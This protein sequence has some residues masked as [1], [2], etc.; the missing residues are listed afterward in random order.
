[1]PR[2]WQAVDIG[3]LEGGTDAQANCSSSDGSIIFGYST[4]SGTATLPFRWTQGTGMV[5][6]ATLEAATPPVAGYDSAEVLS[7]TPDGSVCVGIGFNST[8]DFA[9]TLPVI[10]TGGVPAQLPIVTPGG[11]TATAAAVSPSGGA[12]AGTASG[13]AGAVVEW[14]SGILSALAL[15]D[16]AITDGI[17]AGQAVSNEAALIAGFFIDGSSN[18]HACLWTDGTGADLGLLA[19]GT[20]PAE[21]N[22]ISGDSS[23]VFG[24]CTIASQGAGFTYALP[25]GPMVAIDM[26]DPLGS[27]TDGS[28]IVGQNGSLGRTYDATNLGQELPGTVS[29]FFVTIGAGISANGLVPVGAVAGGGQTH[30]AYWIP[31]GP[32]PGEINMAH[33]VVVSLATE[34]PCTVAQYT[35]APTVSPAVGLRWS[36]NRGKSFGNPVPQGFGTD[37]LTQL[38]WNRTGYARDRVFELFWSVAAP[39]ALNGAFV[40]VDKWK[41]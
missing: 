17:G 9:P 14:L 36:D 15:P 6:M 3:T 33:V 8:D 29:P 31:T 19:G 11:S 7:C 21:A 32:P 23:T 30:A 16:T 4:T 5:A 24:F 1:M 40:I 13:G 26:A 18:T 10:W 34:S 25:S 12:V 22:G 41:T 20:Y 27:S 2:T 39:S 38:Q 35:A 28:V 37:P